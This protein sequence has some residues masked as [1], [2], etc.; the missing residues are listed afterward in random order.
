VVEEGSK[1]VGLLLLPVSEKCCRIA[2]VDIDLI[3]AKEPPCSGAGF[4][5]PGMT[6][7]RKWPRLSVNEL[8]CGEVAKRDIFCYY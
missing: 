6:A 7:C 1:M 4:G 8:G 5:N 3:N 2:P